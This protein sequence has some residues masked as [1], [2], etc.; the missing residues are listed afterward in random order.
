MDC[1]AKKD[2]CLY[3]HSDFPCKFFH[4]G[5]KC[6]AGE[7]CKFSHGVLTDTMKAI[8]LKVRQFSPSLTINVTEL[9]YTRMTISC[10]FIT[11]GGCS[12]FLGCK[13]DSSYLFINCN[14][15]NFWQLLRCT[16]LSVH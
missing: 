7:R 10:N 1:C 3:M 15:V 13:L 16:I 4:T 9:L 11:V 5:L 8:L 6:F 14:Y 2:K 12:V